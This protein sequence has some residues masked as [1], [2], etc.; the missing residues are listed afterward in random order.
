[1]CRLRRVAGLLRFVEIEGCIHV[2]AEGVRAFGCIV[3]A[4][5]HG[6]KSAMQL[7][8]AVKFERDRRALEGEAAEDIGRQ[9]A[10]VDRQPCRAGQ[11]DCLCCSHCYKGTGFVVFHIRQRF[12]RRTI[13]L[14]HYR[15]LAMC[16]RGGTELAMYRVRATVFNRKLNSETLRRLTWLC[17][18]AQFTG[19]VESASPLRPRTWWRL[20]PK[21]ARK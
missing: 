4:I 9:V 15:R 10:A 5:Q 19:R 14:L 20:W 1:M 18:N 13:F 16:W 7:R 6:K 2:Q 17:V 21:P 11:Y 12:L 3:D 8:H